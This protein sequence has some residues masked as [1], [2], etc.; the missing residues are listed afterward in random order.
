[1]ALKRVFVG[2][3]QV[4]LAIPGAADRCRQYWG[5]LGFQERRSPSEAPPNHAAET[6]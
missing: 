3:H 6:A 5:V 1:M 4:Q 2:L